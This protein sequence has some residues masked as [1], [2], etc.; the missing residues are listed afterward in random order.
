[1]MRWRRGTRGHFLLALAVLSTGALAGVGVACATADTLV[2]TIPG[3]D[4]GGVHP[5]SDASTDSSSHD[6]RTDRISLVPDGGADACQPQ[7]SSDLHSVLCNGAVVQTCSADQGCGPKGCEPACQSATDNQSNVGCEFYSVDPDIITEGRGGCFAAF[8]ANVWSEPVTVT[9]DRDGVAFDISGFARVVSGSGSSVAYTAPPGGQVPPGQVAIL[10]L[11]QSGFQACPTGI[12]PAYAGTDSSIDGTGFGQAF[13]ITTSFPVAAYDIYPYGGAT[14]QAT[15]ATMLLPT[16]VWDV[17]YVAV[18]AYHMSSL[19]ELDGGE[20]GWPSLAMVAQADG[21]SITVNPTVPIVGGNGVASA[22][23]GAPTVYTLNAGGV[24]QIRQPDELTG[25]VILANKPIGFWAGHSALNIP[26]N[27]QA[28]DSAHQQVPPV[29]ALG[30]EYVAVRYRGR[31]VVPDPDGGIPS[32]AVVVDGGL[33]EA[34][35]WRLLGIVDGTVLTYDPPTPPA[36]APTTL[37]LGQLVEFNATGPFVVSSQD[38]NHPFYMSAHMTGGAGHYTTYLGERLDGDGDP[39]FVNVV[40]SSQYLSSYLTFT[41]P[42]YPDS[43]LVIVRTKSSMGFEDVTLDCA[44][45][46]SGWSPVGLSGKYEYVRADLVEGDF[47]AQG[48]CNNGPHSL[49]STAPFGVTVWGWAESFLS[50]TMKGSGG[51]VSYAYPGGATI[52]AVNSVVVN[53]VIK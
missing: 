38:D 29:K 39:E 44:G 23:A 8:I 25:S 11:A 50:D 33:E 45:V 17:N 27:A 21:T 28:A 22:E 37:N 5:S 49:S 26:A 53:P 31:S 1:M 35:P 32:G 16:A 48:A 10:F 6:V 12:T 51:Y 18:N 47:Q 46:L 40:P 3:A 13:H 20:V 19:V 7:C 30:S 15:S 9:V 43:E 52:R 14:A 36:G 24:L 42:T 4:G 2:G 34:P 41:D